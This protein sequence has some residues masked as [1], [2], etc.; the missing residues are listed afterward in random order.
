MLVRRMSFRRVLKLFLLVTFTAFLLANEKVGSGP[1]RHTR[2]LKKGTESPPAKIGDVAWIAGHW[3]G[4]GL[5]AEVEEIWTAPA[6]DN[7]MGSFRLTSAGK[8]KFYE[9][10]II[11]EIADTLIL[12]LKHFRPDL[13]GW[14]EKDDTVD[15]K[16]VALGENIAWFDGLTFERISDTEMHVYVVGSREPELHELKFEYTRQ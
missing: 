2:D 9:L 11:R 8:A 7:M 15:F 6:G 5:G 14:E 4:Q 16:L 12:Q 13:K 3:K 10:M 1:E